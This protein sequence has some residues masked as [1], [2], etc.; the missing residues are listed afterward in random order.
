MIP[1]VETERLVL[2]APEMK[3]LPAVTAFFG[4]E[5]SHAVGGPRDDLGSFAA[6]NAGIGHWVTRGFGSWHIADAKTDAEL[7]RTGFI[8]A[9]G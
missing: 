5:Q 1:V 8:L 2:R 9:P 7:G 3:D 4:S 6:I